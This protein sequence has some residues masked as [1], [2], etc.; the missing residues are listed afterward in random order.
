LSSRRRRAEAI[1][2]FG[3]H[4]SSNPNLPYRL[5]HKLPL[6]PYVRAAFRGSDEKH[7]PDFPIHQS[8]SQAAVSL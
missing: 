7:D 1:V 4:F 3:R 8:N 6:T 2:A 5:K